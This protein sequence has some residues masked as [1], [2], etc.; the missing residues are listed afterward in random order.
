MILH[1]A[2]KALD[3][4]LKFVSAIFYQIFVF[5]LNDSPS[6]T[7]KRVFYFITKA[8]FILKKFKLL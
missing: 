8:L 6:K 5:P 1:E 3:P 2:V 7:M 4:S